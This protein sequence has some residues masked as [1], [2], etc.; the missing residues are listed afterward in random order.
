MSETKRSLEDVIPNEYESVLLAAKLSRRINAMR[1]A[2]KEQMAPEE[3]G[4]LDQR[5]VT[6][7]AME[8]LAEGKVLF[9][10]T[11]PIQ[12]EESFDLT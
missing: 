1:V 4:K 11:L 6:T 2:A 7:I 3:F 9:E 8:E 12:E 10:R 5:K